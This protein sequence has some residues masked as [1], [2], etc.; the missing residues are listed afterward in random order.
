MCGKNI[1]CSICGKDTIKAKEIISIPEKNTNICIDCLNTLMNLISGDTDVPIVKNDCIQENKHL[2]DSRL[3]FEVNYNPNTGEFSYPSFNEEVIEEKESK[4]LFNLKPKQIYDELSQYIVGQEQAKKTISVALYNHQ[5]RIADTTGKIK[6]SNILLIGPSGSG[7]TLFA[8]TMSKMLNVPLVIADATSFTATGYIGTDVESILAS[9]ISAADDDI[10]LAEK[11]IVYIDEIDKI[12]KKHGFSDATRDIGGE[13]VQNSLLKILEGSKVNITMKNGYVNETVEID[14]TNI[15]FIC[16]G[17]FTN[18]STIKDNN[19]KKIIGFEYNKENT[20][21][22]LNKEENK[23]NDDI[24][25]KSGLI[26]EF[27]G[28][29]PVR[30]FLNE[31]SEDNMIDILTKTKNSIIDEYVELLKKDKIK[32]TFEKDALMEIVKLAIKKNTGARSLRTI[33]ESVMEDI[34]FEIP[35]MKNV[36][37]CIITKDTVKTKKAKIIYAK[38]KKISA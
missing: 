14:T 18:L 24:L 37:E 15:L 9:L 36:K 16:G 1:K 29:L 19:N 33:I 38:N 6:K 8:Q 11:G 10:E 27:L 23:I 12:Q 32:L 5:K 31:L 4:N 30:V 17:A 13:E 21:R 25:T 22:N 7:K 35:S 2:D 34:M 28:R 20:E 26:P 3:E